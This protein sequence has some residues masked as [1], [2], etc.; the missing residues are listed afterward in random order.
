MSLILLLNPK[1]YGGAPITEADTSDILDR[2]RKRPSREEAALEE[3]LAAQILRKR[4]TEI[5][6]PEAVDRKHFAATL[7]NK[8]TDPS[9]NDRKRKQIHLILL[10]I[11]A[12]DYD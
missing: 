7:R 4:Q 2:Y 5:K 6:L 12:D 3:E 8:L 1:Q 11:A 10:M 9:V